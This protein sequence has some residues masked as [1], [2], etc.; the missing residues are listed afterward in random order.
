MNQNVM[1][2]YGQVVGVILVVIGIGGLLLGEGHLLGALNIDAIEDILH[3]VSGGILAYFAF[4]AARVRELRAVLIVAGIL[5]ALVGVLGWVSPT[6][7]GVIPHAY[8]G[9]DNVIHVVLGLASIGVAASAGGQ[10]TR[11]TETR[12]VA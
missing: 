12:R 1:V 3:I 4:S 2:R 8:T 9:V 7:W 5:Y 11:A 10:V 6:L